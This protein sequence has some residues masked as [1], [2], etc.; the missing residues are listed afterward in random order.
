[1]LWKN[2]FR[3]QFTKP[4]ISNPSANSQT[5]AQALGLETKPLTYHNVFSKKLQPNHHKLNPDWI[6]FYNLSTPFPRKL[7]NASQPHRPSHN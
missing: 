5:P 6:C 3:P 4:Q 1:M 2:Y 7:R